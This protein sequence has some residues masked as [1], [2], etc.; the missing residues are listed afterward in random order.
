MLLGLDGVVLGYL[1]HLQAGDAHFVAARDARRAGI[2]AHR[3]GDDQRRLLGQALG[4]LEDP[5]TDLFLEDDALGEAG[6][7]AYLEELEPPLVGAVI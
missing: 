7:I 1:Q 2:L 3:A 4:R 5:R 6:A